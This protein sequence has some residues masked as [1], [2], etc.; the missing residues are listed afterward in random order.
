MS[1]RNALACLLACFFAMPLSCGAE[2]KPIYKDPK[3]AERL[4]NGDSEARRAII[5]ELF[6]EPKKLLEMDDAFLDA[7]ISCAD[8]PDASV[9]HTAHALIGERWIWK[10]GEQD[11]R[12]IEFLLEQS[13]KEN[14]KIRYACVYYGLS[15]VH[16]M[17]DDVID[18]LIELAVSKDKHESKSVFG[19]VLWGFRGNAQRAGS[20]I[21]TY[22]DRHDGTDSST[23]IRA[24]N[25]YLELTGNVPSG[26]ERFA[27]TGTYK[28]YF[29]PQPP[30]LPKSEDELKQRVLTLAKSPDAAGHVRTQFGAG[31]YFGVVTVKGMP[32][33]GEMLQAMKEDGGFQVAAHGLSGPQLDAFEH[34][35]FGQTSTTKAIQYDKSF[36]DL[37][38]KI[39]AIYPA[40]QI[41]NI[42]WQAV[43][44]ELLPESRT[45]KTHDE[46][47]LLC[48]RLIAR[49]EDSH[50]HLR[51]GTGQP[52]S[53][54]L[55]RWDP[56]FA[57]LNDDRGMPVVYSIDP[58]SPAAEAGLRV[59]MT[60]ESINGVPAAEARQKCSN[61]FK[62]YIGFSSDRL[63]RYQATRWFI[64][65]QDHDSL[66]NLVA[67]DPAGTS[68]EFSMRAT[69][70]VRYLPRLPVP[71]EG[72]SDS[73]NVSWRELEDGIGY[74]YVRRIRG[75]LI[76]DLD[77]AVAQLQTCA[78]LI[79]DVRGNSGGGFDASRSFRNFDL[80][81]K[82]EPDRPRFHGPMAVLIDAR[83]ISAG[84]GWASWFI[85]NKRARFFGEATAGASS[86][87]T[88][89][90]IA[91]GLF[92]ATI[93]VKAY[94]GFLDR[95]IER[96]GLEPDVRVSQ[97]AADLEQQIDTVLETAR[98]YLLRQ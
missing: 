33:Y 64:R 25:L 84:E 70:D 92:R 63:L 48:Q 72:I 16:P 90:S 27:D 15:T 28:I 10:G 31:R 32:S 51:S 97:N 24:I 82:N 68:H 43:G 52:A 8:D 39:G 81:D 65:Q 50:A 45:I 40:F 73:A 95:P 53:P 47:S 34:R 23:A 49:L 89:I 21:Q 46:F 42:D 7:F 17:S 66:V 29:A 60:I 56:G 9:Q 71:M 36:A 5:R 18:R 57:C 1:T 35:A 59:G 20:R 74:I 91:D 76:K 79:I 12:A 26:L 41:K 55:P 83:C 30:F 3:V 38:E 98:E 94:R 14:E 58:N 88:T 22:I 37:F 93:P 44:Q 2:E 96:V 61:Q 6:A 78:G 69:L 11:P 19:R 62:E 4:K 86:R 80:D 85:A 77:Q 54:S 13:Q 67:V 75:D 87:K